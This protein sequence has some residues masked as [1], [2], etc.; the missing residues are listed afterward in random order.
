MSDTAALLR[1]MHEA[2]ADVQTAVGAAL[3]ALARAADAI[4]ARLEAGGRWIY[5]GAGTSGRLGALDAAEIPPT[6]G[7]D[8]SLVVALLAGGKDAMFEAVEGAEDDAEA[9]AVDLL[10]AGLTSNDAVVGIAASGGTPYVRGA[11]KE[12]RARGAL[13]V[14]VVCR[15]GAPLLAEADIGILLDTGKEILAESSRL[16]AG[17][18]QKI[19]L[20]MLSTAVMAKRGLVY[21]G[22]MVAMRPTNEKLRKRAKRIVAQLAGTS[23]EAAEDLL[24]RVSWHLP[25]A[26]VAA[27]WKLDASAASLHLSR[28]KFN[29]AAALSQPPETGGR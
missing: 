29:V 23:E 14:S 16:K 6:F 2:D 7:T 3:P 25:S 24:G 13:T 21:E 27:K 1:R 8:P 10:R 18:A 12:A 9:G 22:E 28:K 17:T 20:N 26:L 4:A 11:L 5:V 19:A 15:P